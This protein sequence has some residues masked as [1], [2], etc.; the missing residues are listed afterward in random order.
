MQMPSDRRAEVARPPVRQ[1]V[2]ESLAAL[3]W[4]RGHAASRF[5]WCCSTFDSTDAGNIG[6]VADALV[7]ALELRLRACLSGIPG[8]ARAALPWAICSSTAHCWAG[9]AWASS[10]DADDRRQSEPA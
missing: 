9:A 10:A 8:P 6:P 2:D 3:A 1:A 7:A 4:L 5:F